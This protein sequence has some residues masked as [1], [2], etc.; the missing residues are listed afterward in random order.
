MEWLLENKLKISRGC[1][2]VYG[3][4]RNCTIK[5]ADTLELNFQNV[6]FCNKY[7]IKSWRGDFYT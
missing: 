1:I 6:T 2:Y 7:S 3:L 5:R 4:F